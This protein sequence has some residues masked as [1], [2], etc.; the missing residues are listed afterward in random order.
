MVGEITTGFLIRVIDKFSKPMA[1]AEKMVKR[2]TQ[3]SGGLTG[4]LKKESEAE[5][6]LAVARRYNTKYVVNQAAATKYLQSVGKLGLETDTAK[7]S[8]MARML[9]IMRKVA[10][11]GITLAIA[12]AT[13]NE[14][15]ASFKLS[16][17]AVTGSS[18][19]AEAIF[20]RLQKFAEIVPIPLKQIVDTDA[21]LIQ[22]TGSQK[23]AE[24]ITK[25][26]TIVSGG[27]ETNLDNL[28]KTYVRVTQTGRFGRAELRSFGKAMP[29]VIAEMRRIAKENGIAS[30][31]F[32][33]A[34]ISGR[35]H[36]EWLVDS[37]ERM[38]NK[39][40]IAYKLMQK[41]NESFMVNLKEFGGIAS[42]YLNDLWKMVA[43]N[44][45]LGEAFH[46]LNNLLR[47]IEPSF[48]R[49]TEAIHDMFFTTTRGLE[50]KL[51]FGAITGARPKTPMLGGKIGELLGGARPS[52]EPTATAVKHH[53]KITIDD[54]KGY[55]KKVEPRSE[56][57]GTEFNLGAN[58]AHVLA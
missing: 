53:F 38:A 10:T 31:S 20:N 48:K 45:T 4:T 25:R 3:A 57:K 33:K 49:A 52:P 14:R 22:L 2:L 21:A 8:I 27:L 9:P 32:D 13:A 11:A 55:V 12:A 43:G 47:A 46:K 28:A 40:G 26:L 16:L 17:E 1:Q 36:S 54:P 19:D 39:G 35:F 7:L 29:Y 24:K 56:D 41:R 50:A 34:L 23:E 58:M 5:K 6:S 42:G 30:A 51:G 15:F 44:V 37:L 18:K